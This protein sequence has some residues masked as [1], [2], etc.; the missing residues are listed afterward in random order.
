MPFGPKWR[1]ATETLAEDQASPPAVA[2]DRRALRESVDHPL[3]EPRVRIQLGNVRESRPNH[4]R[5][6]P[7]STVPRQTHTDGLV[8][9]VPLPLQS[10][11]EI[12]CSGPWAVIRRN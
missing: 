9:K 10:G 12:R 1:H 2:F 8:T 6:P 5:I 11:P 7:R 4:F 3:T